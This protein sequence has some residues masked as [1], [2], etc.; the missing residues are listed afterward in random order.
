MPALNVYA[1]ES[2]NDGRS[3]F[4]VAAVVGTED[5]WAVA[6]REWLRRTRGL[7]FHAAKCESEHA[8]NPDRGPHSENLR[9]YRDLTTILAV[10]HLVGISIALDVES[11][12]QLLPGTP[13][14][15][16][17][18]KCFTDLIVNCARMARQYNAE[19]KEPDE[20]VTLRF[21]F[22]SRRESDGTAGAIY[23]VFQNVPAWAD[24]SIF[25][26]PIAFD[27]KSNPRL[28]A[29][30]LLAREAMKEFDRKLTNVRPEPRRSFQTLERSGRFRWVEYD[31]TYCQ[32]WRKRVDSVEGQADFKDYK[33]WL[34]NTGRVQDG[35]PHDNMANRALFYSW[36]EK[37][38]ALAR[39]GVK[40]K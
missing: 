4:A 3:V 21:T 35:N 29:A 19:R 10:S 5:E 7:P 24:A 16:A 37:R 34:A 38:D 25:D 11:Q 2:A 31:H 13:T 30:D 33:R 8:R 6:I 1:D 22:E 15:L 40:L 18:Y 32:E 12:R 14:D 28:E 17:Y 26:T 9:L 23:S 20:A 36:V 27:T 39:S